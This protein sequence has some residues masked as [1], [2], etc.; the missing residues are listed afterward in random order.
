[1]SD[2]KVKW[3]TA[4]NET[5]TAT[6]KQHAY[7]PIMRKTPIIRD[8]YEGNRSLCRSGFGI[9]EDGELYS[10]WA[11]IEGENMNPEKCCKQ[12]LRIFNAKNL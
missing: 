8:T 12:C 6:L 10:D 5:G 11:T 3:F 1:M 9:S 4:D 7:I 2:V